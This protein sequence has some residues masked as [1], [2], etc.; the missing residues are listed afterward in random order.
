MSRGLELTTEL[1]AGVGSDDEM[2]PYSEK[3]KRKMVQRMSGPS[4]TTATASL[5]REVGIAQG[6]LSRWLRSAGTIDAVKKSKNLIESDPR[7]R[8]TEE[9]SAED[10]FRLVAQAAQLSESELGA[11]LRREGLHH[12]DLDA[13]RASMLAAL[14]PGMVQ[15][16]AAKSVEV[17]KV[18]ELSLI[19]I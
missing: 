5:S 4:P 3:F 1:D 11:F 13:W 19:H 8:R 14:S 9:R 2:Q 18:R 6:T 12:A 15:S 17:R 7:P 10:K 16:K